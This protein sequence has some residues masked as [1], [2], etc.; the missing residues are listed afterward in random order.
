MR[1][2]LDQGTLPRLVN[3]R[4]LNCQNPKTR[5]CCCHPFLRNGYLPSLSGRVEN[6]VQGP[7]P[8]AGS[9]RVQAESLALLKHLHT[10]PDSTS[11]WE[12]CQA[13]PKCPRWQF[14]FLSYK[15]VHFCPLQTPAAAP[16]THV[17]LEHLP[18]FQ[19]TPEL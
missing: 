13:A 8:S 16:G 15:N 17:R 2:K 10:S 1:T 7:C 12:R 4:S 18:R 11:G 3:R 9:P 5:P 14:C 6:A 19:K